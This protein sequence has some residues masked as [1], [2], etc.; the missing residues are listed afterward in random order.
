MDVLVQANDRRPSGQDS[1]SPVQSDAAA[2]PTAYRTPHTA[3]FSAPNHAPPT[4]SNPRGLTMLQDLRY[5]LRQLRRTPAFTAVAILTL[6]LG[7]GANT[8]I[9][10]VMNAVMLRYLPVR[11]PQ[12]LVD[13]HI[14]RTPN[15]SSQTGHGDSSLTLPIFEALRKQKDAFADVVAYVPLGID[16]VPVRYGKEPEEAQADMVSGNFFSCLGVHQ[17]GRAHV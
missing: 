3:Y 1:H 11:D 15:N 4:T 14:T 5:A 9:F 6:A 12:Q 7:I 17:I 16:K 10:S 2:G 8:A 13:L